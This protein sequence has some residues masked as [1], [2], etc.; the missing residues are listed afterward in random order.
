MAGN[1]AT[2]N[3]FLLQYRPLEKDTSGI[4]LFS[5]VLSGLVKF[6]FSNCLLILRHWTLLYYRENVHIMVLP[7]AETIEKQ[8]MVVLRDRQKDLTDFLGLAD[9]SMR[10]TGSLYLIFTFTFNCP[11]N[12]SPAGLYD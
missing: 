7:V 1:F 10:N 8:L 3:I 12:W 5:A 11:Y 9:C 6:V 2:K 4:Y